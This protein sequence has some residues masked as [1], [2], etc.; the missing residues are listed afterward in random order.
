MEMEYALE[1]AKISHVFVEW[2]MA[3]KD[4]KSQL[5]LL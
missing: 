2:D 5:D 4:V 1:I 3:G